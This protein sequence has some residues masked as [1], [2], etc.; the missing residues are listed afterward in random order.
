LPTPAL[1]IATAHAYSG[2]PGGRNA[3]PGTQDVQ[4]NVSA[5]CNTSP[6]F[7]SPANTLTVDPYAD[8]KTYVLGLIGIDTIP[9]KVHAQ[10]CSPCATT[11]LDVMIVLDRTG[12][13]AG[14][15]IQNAEQGVEGF[16]ATLD[17]PRGHGG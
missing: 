1:A 14:Q 8:V 4:L 15:K 7:C 3:I 2:E 13:M 10:A 16:L 5:N 9:V 11:P 17:T 12:S 6:K